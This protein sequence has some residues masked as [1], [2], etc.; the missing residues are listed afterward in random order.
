MTEDEAHAIYKNDILRLC[1]VVAAVSAGFATLLMATVPTYRTVHE[2]KVVT[3]VKKTKE[4]IEKTE[5][6]LTSGCLQGKS[7]TIRK[8]HSEAYDAS[9]KEDPSGWIWKPFVTIEIDDGPTVV[10]EFG[11]VD[12]KKTLNVGDSFAPAGG[13]R[14]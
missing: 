8:V 5:V 11:H 9:S 10:C 12:L 4:T 7:G 13:E 2:T 3:T 6:D 14:L 1:A